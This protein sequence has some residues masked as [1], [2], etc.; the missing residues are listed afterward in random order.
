MRE[1]KSRADRGCNELRQAFSTMPEPVRARY[2][3]QCQALMA[4]E[5]PHLGTTGGGQ[6]LLEFFGGSGANLFLEFTSGCKIRK[7]LSIMERAKTVA[8][9]HESAVRQLESQV[10]GEEQQAAGQK[11]S[12]ESAI[13]TE[14][15]RIFDQLRA[16][17]W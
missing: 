17:A 14:R 4:V 13:E 2:P 10:R 8:S 5:V 1:A 11:A 16:T 6:K 7:N 3:T 9:E 12:V 15:T